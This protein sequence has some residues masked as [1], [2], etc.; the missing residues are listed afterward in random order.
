MPFAIWCVLIAGLM[1]IV[2]AGIAKRGDAS[3]D[4]GNPR[5]WEA[6]LEGWR[7]RV[8][9]AHRNGFEVFPFFAAAVL[10][11]WTQGAAQTP[12]D[13]L[14][15][16]FILFRIAYAWAY[17]ADRASLRSALFGGGFFA[18]IAIF[19]TPLFSGGA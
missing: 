13:C 4:N 5:G 9:A 3:F 6:G 14:A 7:K 18:T 1:P 2:L 10:S 11:A 15:G 12:V 8:Y 17:Y 19:L 16:A